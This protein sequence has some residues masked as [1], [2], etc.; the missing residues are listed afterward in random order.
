MYILNFAHPLTDE[1]RAQVEALTGLQTT[2]IKTIKVQV[3]VEQPLPP[4]ISALVDTIGFTADEWQNKPMVINPPGLSTA[5]AV[6]M[7]ELHGRM[8]YFPPII[9][10]K[11]EGTPPRFVVAEVI[12]LAD[13]RNAARQKR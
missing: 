4:Q 7:A 5:A 1:Q 9:R 12:N 13:V 6:L 8:G 11:Q 3:D 10:L 2:E